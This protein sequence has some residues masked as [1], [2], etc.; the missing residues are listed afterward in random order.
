MNPEIMKATNG[1]PPMVRYVEGGQQS[2]GMVSGKLILYAVFKRKWQV[3]AVIA[4]VVAS[5][6][7]A[8]LV[9]PSVYKS[10]VKVMIRPGR[11][12]IQ[13]GAGEQREITIPVSA[14]TEMINSEMEIL[15]SADLMRHTIE[16][17]ERAGE[18]I[19]GADT[20]MLPAEQIAAL[21]EMIAVSPA[22]QSNVISIDLLA[23]DPERGQAILAAYTAAYLER[24]AE[25]HGSAGASEF[26]ERQ[27]RGLRKR[28]ART[29]AKL[30]AFVTREG[31][32]LPEDQIRLTLRAGMQGSDA[33]GVQAAKLRGLEQRVGILQQQLNATPVTIVRDVERVHATAQGLAYELAKREAERATLL[34]NYTEEDRR[35]R[36]ISGEIETLKQHIAEADASYVIGTE[37]ISLNPVRLDIERRLINQKLNLDD[38]RTRMESLRESA[39]LGSENASKQAVS[40]R[41][42]TYRLNS[43]QEELVAA[44]EAYQRYE[45]KYDEA[46]IAQALDEHGIINVSVLDTPSLPARPFNR[47]S[48]LMMLAALVAGAGLGVGSAV[49][50]ELLGRNFKFEEQVEQYLELPVF[51]VIPDMTE[52]AESA[53]T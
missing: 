43:L 20:K 27:L 19:F 14:T 48:P 25:L 23:R 8:G 38:L 32:A 1:S 17:M 34:Q 15:R 4:V 16:R 12:E 18:P 42:K 35:V 3:L 51:A 5:I 9:R 13:I 37:R 7:V 33:V 24:H 31:L 22:P 39:Q 41:R 10:N 52:V 2:D 29:D 26:F 6:L 36:D 47:M 45:R 46:R 21:R 49:G 50:L 30:A 44:R 40:L 11:A 53:S 28:I